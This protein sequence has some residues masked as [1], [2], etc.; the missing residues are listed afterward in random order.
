MS[1]AWLIEWQ[2]AWPID[3]FKV[4]STVLWYFQLPIQWTKK[5]KTQNILSLHFD[6]RIS[7]PSDFVIVPL[8]HNPIELTG[9]IFCVCKLL[10]WLGHQTLSFKKWLHLATVNLV[11]EEDKFLRG[12]S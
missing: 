7:C 1:Q 11:F 6:N 2:M 8:W 5:N 9:G 12:I 10:A 3:G 4:G